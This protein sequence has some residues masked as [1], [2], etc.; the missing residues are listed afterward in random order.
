MKTLAD[1]AKHSYR[2]IVDVNEPSV[3][4]CRPDPESKRGGLIGPLATV[5]GG[6]TEEGEDGEE[7]LCLDSEDGCVLYAIA[8]LPKLAELV[9]WAQVEME[10][11]DG[12][13]FD[14]T[15]ESGRF[16]AEL[17]K[18]VDWIISAVDDRPQTIWEGEWGVA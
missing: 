11:L 1:I 14:T 2:M 3:E 10:K 9:T 4:I 7:V 13:H 17:R 15:T 12:I 16:H 18:R 6:A 8:V 5:N